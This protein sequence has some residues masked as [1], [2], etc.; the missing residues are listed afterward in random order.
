MIFDDEPGG[1]DEGAP[2]IDASLAAGAIALVGSGLAV[3][4]V[5]RSK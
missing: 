1:G 2:E 4:S 5:R 3:M